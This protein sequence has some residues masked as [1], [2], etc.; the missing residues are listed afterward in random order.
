MAMATDAVARGPRSTAT[1]RLGIA[2][3]IDS[4]TAIG[5]KD[6]SGDGAEM[7]QPQVHRGARRRGDFDGGEIGLGDADEVGRVGQV[8][9]AETALGIGLDFGDDGVAR[10]TRDSDFDAGERVSVIILHRA[11]FEDGRREG[12]GAERKQQKTG[13]H[14]DFL[15]LF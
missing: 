6:P 15:H 11:A 1:P 5:A 14:G 3:D 4:R 9:G 7:D 12:H 13:L 2:G 10:G 8:G